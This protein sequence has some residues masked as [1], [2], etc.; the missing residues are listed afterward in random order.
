[1]SDFDIYLDT[2]NSLAFSVDIAGAAGSSVRSQF[3]VEGPNGISFCFGGRNEG[4]EIHVEIPVLKNM[5][6]EGKY[7]TRLEVIIDDRVFVPLELQTELRR[8]VTIEAAVK[9]VN[10]TQPIV[11]AAV[12]NRP[13]ILEQTATVPVELEPTSAEKEEPT[14]VKPKSARQEKPGRKSK[15]KA[16][17]R[18]SAKAKTESAK[19]KLKKRS[20]DKKL[21]DT[22]FLELLESYDLI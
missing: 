16:L 9:T 18:K 4:K 20:S 11:T 15:K 21:K 13:K 6:S 19:R 17:V 12:I 8:A 3:I 14:E 10:R 7:S 5:I 22:E 2:D 1:M